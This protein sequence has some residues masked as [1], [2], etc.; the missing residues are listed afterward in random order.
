MDR[1][2][3]QLDLTDSGPG[4]PGDA[5]AVV[6]AKSVVAEWRDRD[7]TLFLFGALSMNVSDEVGV[8][9]VELIGDGAAM[10]T[11][12]LAGV[13][14]IDSTGIRALIKV[15]RRVEEVG[16]RM[17]ITRPSKS[18]RRML[19]LVHLDTVIP[20]GPVHDAESEGRLGRLLHEAEAEDE[21]ED[22][23]GLWS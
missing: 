16:G 10:V 11:V 15:Q 2:I 6:H 3:E 17:M 1:T 14:F 9:A 19:T 8:E 20:I 13:N 12:D 18:A 5:D 7:L 23:G 22:D 21:A 4:D